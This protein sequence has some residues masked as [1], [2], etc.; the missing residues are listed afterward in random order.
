M[1][2]QFLDRIISCEPGISAVG[3]KCFSRSELFFMDHFPGFP[4]VPGVLQIEMMAQMAGKCIAIKNPLILPV[5]GS[6][7]NSKFYRNINPGDQCKI[8]AQIT[9]I[10]KQY[11]TAEC[12]I[13][14]D[15]LKVSSA[16]ILFAFLPR[17][18]L[19]SENFDGVTQEW[20]KKQEL[21]D[22]SQ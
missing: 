17:T 6:V 21:E 7:K 2:W 13:E 3:I 20:L 16:E 19:Q 15:G 11:G 12:Y 9:K 10:A 14:V 22:Q 1:R 18:H 5:L 4:I 8:Y